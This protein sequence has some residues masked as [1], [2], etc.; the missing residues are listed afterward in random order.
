MRVRILDRAAGDLDVAARAY[1][2][3]SAGLGAYFFA[4]LDAEIRALQK[5]VG[6]HPLVHGQHCLFSKTFPYA[7]YYEI[8]RDVVLINAVLGSRLEPAGILKKVEA[9]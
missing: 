3:Q 5:F 6:V 7:I 9:R 1:E 8:E 2:R 4:T